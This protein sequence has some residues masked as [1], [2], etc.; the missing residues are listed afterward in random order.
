M[1]TK[2]KTFQGRTMSEALANV[3]QA[4]GVNAI[5]LHTRT[6][7][8]GGVL[9]MGARPVVEITAST[10]ERVAEVQRNNLQRERVAANGE[11]TKHGSAASGVGAQGRAALTAYGGQA[12]RTEAGATQAADTEKLD[13]DRMGTHEAKHEAP[14]AQTNAKAPPSTGNDR[15]A[16]K[17]IDL[18]LPKM[19]ATK[20]RT[21]SGSDESAMRAELNEIRQ[22][23]HELVERS[24]RT[25]YPDAPRQLVNFYTYLIGQDVEEQL[26]KELLQ[27]VAKNLDVDNA[28]LHG[29]VATEVVRMELKRLVGEMLPAAAPL[30]LTRTDKPT[31]VALVGPT[32]VGKTTTIAK[33]AANMKLR[34][35]KNVGLITIDSYRIAAVEQLKTYA[36]ILKVPLLSVLKPNDMAD[37]LQRMSN[38][39]LVLIDTA[40][41]SQRDDMRIAELSS[42]LKVAQPD[43]IHLVLSSTSRE[44]TTREAIDRFAPLGVSQL[45]F[46]KVDEAV[47]M[48]VL[49]NVLRR[50]KLRVS[51]LTHG[52]AVPDDI[53]VASA[54]RLARLILGFKDHE[55]AGDRPAAA[56]TVG[57]AR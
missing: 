42:F 25:Q 17:H 7:Q 16:D 46:T 12:E 30:R 2:I 40:G 52:Q 5:I 49:L 51:Y 28:R 44:R 6:V 13:M 48:G 31:V 34:E 19:P 33:L 22:M 24:D 11:A 8:R 43:Q 21:G 14:L 45:I 55:A 54:S 36:Q 27:R 53:E 9:G 39:D 10:D 35:K 32:G 37:A 38:L 29:R 50:V 57:G 18:Q 4:L 26:A 56:T 41:R 3:K 47:G 20:L 23:V 15:L 1:S